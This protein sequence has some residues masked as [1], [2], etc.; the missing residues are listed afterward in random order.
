MEA[1]ELRSAME[2]A[3]GELEH[4]LNGYPRAVDKLLARIDLWL[5]GEDAVFVE[6]GWDADRADGTKAWNVIEADRMWVTLLTTRFVLRVGINKP[7][8]SAVFG[9]V[10]EWTLVER[11]KLV[12]LEPF[13]SGTEWQ[14]G[15][16][17]RVRFDGLTEVLEVPSSWDSTSSVGDDR[18]FFRSLRDDLYAE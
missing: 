3:W 5:D 13:T 15:M 10:A 1:A 11:R 7:P 17:F 14:R 12:E 2:R 4:R 9:S 8:E 16:R 18:A 6:F